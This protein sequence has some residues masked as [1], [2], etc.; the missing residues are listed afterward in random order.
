MLASHMNGE[1][2]RK[3]ETQRDSMAVI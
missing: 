3:S 1:I 2:S